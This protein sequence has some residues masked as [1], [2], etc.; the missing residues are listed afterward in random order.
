[1]MYGGPYIYLDESICW[2]GLMNN[3]MMVCIGGKNK[4]LLSTS[5]VIF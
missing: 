3:K 1:M 5:K 2:P 4:V